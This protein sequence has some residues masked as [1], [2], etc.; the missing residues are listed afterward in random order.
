MLALGEMRLDLHELMIPLRRL[1]HHAR[2]NDQD[3]DE[4]EGRNRT[5]ERQTN[6]KNAVHCE[7]LY[8]GVHPVLGA[9]VVPPP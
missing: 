3:H 2:S 6:L 1:L 4:G 7:T 8:G 5:V 9:E